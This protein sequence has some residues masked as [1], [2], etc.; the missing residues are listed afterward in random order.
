M[1]DGSTVEMDANAY[2]E[3]LK[4]EADALRKELLKAEQQKQQAQLS[5]SS[6]I[7]SYVA[8][9]PE[10]QLKVLTSGIS[11]DVVAAMRQLVTYILRAPSGDEPL[12][13]DAEVT[14][15]QAKL[16]QLC[17]YQLILGYRLREAEATGEADE[18]IGR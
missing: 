9:L 18:Q 16:Q 3:Q 11:D 13:K 5:I 2:M 6:S 14:L 15:E 17:L 8:S 7:S 1:D 10:A 4:E 12:P